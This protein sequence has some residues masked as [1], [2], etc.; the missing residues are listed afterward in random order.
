MFLLQ[1]AVISHLRVSE[2]LQEVADWVWWLLR[3]LP[4]VSLLIKGGN[5]GG[6]RGAEPSAAKQAAFILHSLDENSGDLDNL[7]YLLIW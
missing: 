4:V 5:A 3:L 7:T 2:L 6:N 1:T